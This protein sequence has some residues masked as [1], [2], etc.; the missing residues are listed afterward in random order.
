M[1]PRASD[2]AQCLSRGRCC[3]DGQVIPCCRR[4]GRGIVLL[5]RF[6][7]PVLFTL[8]THRTPIPGPPAALRPRVHRSHQ[9]TMQPVLG[10]KL[11]TRLKTIP[12]A[13]ELF[14]HQVAVSGLQPTL[15][16]TVCLRK[17]HPEQVACDVS[18]CKRISTAE[19]HVFCARELGLSRPRIV[20]KTVQM[21]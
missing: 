6:P 1:T 13:H 5:R 3:A 14:V 10:N 19:R 18:E 21:S 2:D 11:P 8:C 20:V 12:W 9:R 4:P 17:V 7:A 15:Q 16:K